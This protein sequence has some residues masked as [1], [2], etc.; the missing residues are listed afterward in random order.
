MLL[1]I[2]KMFCFCDCWQDTSVVLGS[3]RGQR[4]SFYQPS[5]CTSLSSGL[6]PSNM[7]LV[8]VIV[9]LDAQPATQPQTM[10]LS[11]TAVPDSIPTA[12]RRVK[13]K[14]PKTTKNKKGATLDF[15]GPPCILQRQT[16]ISVSD[17]LIMVLGDV[18]CPDWLMT[19][20]TL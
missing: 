17:W 4:L 2:I 14:Q 7:R 19:L 20:P 1:V 13:H 16:L 8:C 6:S 15:Y 11:V 12:N 5:L 10:S 3:P 9:P 18:A